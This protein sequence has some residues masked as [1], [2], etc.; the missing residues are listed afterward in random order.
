[1]LI[2]YG[3][4]LSS[5]QQ[6]TYV[7]KILTVKTTTDTT[8]VVLITFINFVIFECYVTVCYH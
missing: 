4:E 6:S 7:I 3:D 2:N 8:F 5:S 1:M